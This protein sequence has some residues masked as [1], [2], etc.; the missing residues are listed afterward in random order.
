MSSIYTSKS[1]GSI[2]PPKQF[3]KKLNLCNN[4]PGQQPQKDTT[5]SPKVKTKYRS[6]QMVLSFN[7]KIPDVGKLPCPNISER[8][9][10]AAT[11]EMLCL[12]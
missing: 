11:L 2:N 1:Q 3:E 6:D 5:K 9:R 4:T 12:Y 7:K 8:E 10:Q